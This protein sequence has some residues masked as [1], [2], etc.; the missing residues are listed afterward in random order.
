MEKIIDLR[1]DTVTQP[2]MQMRRD[3]SR[4]EVGD[5]VYQ[6]DPT[7]NKLEV[8]AAQLFGKEAALFIASGTMGNLIAMLSH[9][10][11]GNEVILE[12]DAHIFHYEAGGVSRIAGLVPHLI[13]GKKGIFSIDQLQAAVRPDD[14]HH[15]QTTLMCL[16]N[17]HN[18]AG[19]CVLP[20]DKVVSL[21]AAARRLGLKLHLDGARIFNAAVATN[22]TVKDLAEPFDSVTFCLSKGLASPVG[23]LLVGTKKFINQARKY[24]KILGGGMRQAGILAAAGLESLM[25]MTKRLDEDHRRA[26][27]LAVALSD[28]PGL[29]IVND[30][31]TNMIMLEVTKPGHTAKDLTEQWQDYRIAAVPVSKQC[32]RLVTH[33]QIDDDDIDWIINVTAKLFGA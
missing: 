20:Q 33:Y 23:S 4:A 17:T 2:T 14:I 27:Q 32:L 11:P 18:R 7:V 22:T 26:K 8:Y 5:D 25:V 13:P 10:S 6:E 19:G 24:R 9:T 21:T 12:A 30:V 28:I 16:E 15:P 29:S 31:Q 1:S 3:M